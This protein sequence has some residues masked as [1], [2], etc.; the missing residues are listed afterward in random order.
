V[1]QVSGSVA[2][3]GLTAP[4]RIV[5]DTWGVPH[6]YAQS[7]DDL[8]F[9]Q[10]F[11]QAQD[12]LFQMD[13]WRRSAQGRLSE[14]LGPNFI[15]RDAMTRRIQYRGDPDAEWAS[16]GPDAKTIA[17]AFVRGVNAWVALARERPPEEFVLAGWTPDLWS[18]V[19]LLNR[20]DAFT[21]SGDAI[22]EIVRARLA[23]TVGAARAR[24]LLPR[25]RAIDIPAGLDITAVPDL[26]AD[27]IR[28]VGTLPFFVGLAAPV[29]DGTVRLKPDT[30]YR[31]GGV[32]SR[33]VQ[34]QPDLGGVVP[35][36]VQLQPD[37]GGVVPSGVQLQPDLGGVVPSGVRLQP[38]R[39][40]TRRFDH[41]SLR[42]FIHLNAPG[43]NVIGATAPWRPGVAVGH[44]DRIAWTAEPFDADTQD[45]Y[46]EKLNPSN[47]H[48]VEDG[49][50]WVDVETRTDWITVRGRKT[51]VDFV[52]ETTRHG[53]IVASDRER[54]FAFAVRWSGSE[55]GAGAELAAPALDRATSWPA[56]RSALARWKMPARRMTY[57]D[58]DGERG[59]QVAA[60]VPFRRGWNGAIPTP[61]WTAAT[62]WTGWRTLDDLPHA[63]NPSTALGA[64]RAQVPGA[65]PRIDAR[66]VPSHAIA[67][68]MILDAIRLHPDRADA[69][70]KRLAAVTS[71]PD[72][73]T[74]QQA[75]IV[76]ALAEALRDRL[77][78]PGGPVLFAHLLGVTDAARR[79][80]NVTARARAGA[81][82]E[83]F[84]ITFSPTDWDRSMAI[85]APGQSG[86]PE[87]A[88]FADLVKLW[89]D[90]EYFP[91]AFSERAVRAHTDAMLT[92]T[93]K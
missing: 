72:A 40:P 58:A 69:L 39:D 50:R 46:V 14:V 54:H 2:V 55:P 13:L 20:T 10:G 84:A 85:S 45:V 30:T 82:A 66:A 64:G 47:P 91:L 65:R 89:S 80:F 27:A 53:V 24:L 68:Q 57:A 52:R 33:G 12:R 60:L 76:D 79:R 56:F 32:V 23:A 49:G 29:P 28:R 38:D 26:V 48:Q 6:I 44:N 87:S 36:G 73:L 7:D 61:G 15:E 1:P 11:V 75:V 4:V 67:T 70:L 74:S 5:R 59:F 8:F 86:S 81:A 3:A 41:P 43:W 18:P 90:G 62:E 83:P 19:D 93:P 9:A 88:H 21:A 78:P 16:Y 34:L 25:E 77:L 37:L 63:L 35:S 71:S 17:T 31:E 92:L 22:D 51:P 42:Y